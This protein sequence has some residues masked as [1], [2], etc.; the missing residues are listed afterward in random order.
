MNCRTLLFLFFISGFAAVAQK[1]RLVSKLEGASIKVITRKEDELLDDAIFNTT[2]PNIYMSGLTMGGQIKVLSQHKQDTAFVGID[3]GYFRFRRNENLV[4][5]EHPKYRDKVELL[6]FERVKG[7]KKRIVFREFEPLPKHKETDAYFRITR[8]EIEVPSKSFHQRHY[9]GYQE[10]LKN[11]LDHVY[12][13]TRSF[14]NENSALIDKANVFLAKIGFNDTLNNLHLGNYSNVN[15]KYTI[16]SLIEHKFYPFCVVEVK[17]TVKFPDKFGVNK[18][19][20]YSARSRIAYDYSPENEASNPELIQ[21]AVNNLIFEILNDK[22]VEASIRGLDQKAAGAADK[23]ALITLANTNTLSASLESAA[24]A[25]V[26]VVQKDGHGS[27]C[28][29]SNDGYIVTNS[30]VIGSDTSDIH[31]IFNNGVK[32]KASFIRSNP[33]YDLLLLQVDSVISVPLKINR[34]PVNM[35]AEVY[36]IGTPKDIGLGQTVSRG[37]I[38]AKRTIEGKT[39]LQSDVSVNHGNSGGAMINKD[40]ELI[41]VVASKL[42]GYGV[43]GV[44]FAIPVNYIEEALKVK[45]GE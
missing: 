21:D 31:V 39:F 12:I 45:I 9:E 7:D 1:V 22:T 41:G 13:S 35:G 14:Q 6:N 43:E 2:S 17:A 44:S 30:H 27:G 33:A 11:D 20:K 40:G 24:A 26:T 10:Y 29:L 38:S 19:K 34:N 28:I 8:I 32:K 16:T 42:V 15:L 23:F 37:I 18:V 25:V 3:S 5:F 36:A 4:L